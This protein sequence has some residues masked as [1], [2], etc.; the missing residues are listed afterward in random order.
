ML[1]TICKATGV[2]PPAGT[3]GTSL[4]PTLTG[5]GKQIGQ[6]YLYW[7]FPSYGGQQA[8]RMGQWK[9]V[10]TNLA[11]DNRMLQFFDL[12]KDIGEQHDVSAEHPQVLQQMFRAMQSART[13]AASD[14]WDQYFEYR[15]Q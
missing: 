15:R 6:E 7:E 5:R 10:R 4:M 1:P 13:P 11:R 12:S 8:M 2:K 9:S 3:D 14:E